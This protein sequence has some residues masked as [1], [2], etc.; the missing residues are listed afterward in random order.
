MISEVDVT[1]GSGLKITCDRDLLVATLATVSRVVSSRGSVQVLSGVLL[2][3]DGDRLELA[4]TDME[5]SLRTTF[6][7]QVEG[8]SSVVVP[9]KLLVDLARL[10]PAAEVTIEYRPEDG[11]VHVSSGSYSSKLNVF[12]AEDFPRLPVIEPSRHTIATASLLDT[13]DRVARS[14]SKD[15]SRPVLTGIQVRFEGKKL[16]MAAT[17]SYRLSFKETELETEGPELEAIIP[18]RALAELARIAAGTET[19]ELGVNENTVVF[20]TGDT[21]LTTRRIDGQ[22]PDVSRLLPESFDIEVDLPRAELRDVVR[23]AAVMALRNAPLRLRFADGELTV[24]AQSQDVGETSE[25]LPAGY[26]GE[27]LEIGFNAEF[28]ADGV[29]SVRGDTVRMKLINPLRAGLITSAD[30]SFW[31]LIMPIRLAG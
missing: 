17:D 14:A 28:L 19:V 31:Y 30:D 6:E 22:F 27:P 9:G 24:S 8:D 5:L 21:W 15:E 4:A 2:R 26:T 12:A 7:A 13:V 16:F 25:S 18:A 23:R 20:G 3:P 1:V 11:V 10:L 29:E